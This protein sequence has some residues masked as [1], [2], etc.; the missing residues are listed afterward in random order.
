MR[1]DGEKLIGEAIKANN[2]AEA[3]LSEIYQRVIPYLP[4]ELV[5]DEFFNISS[6]NNGSEIFFTTDAELGNICVEDV[7]ALINK[8][9]NLTMEDIKQCRGI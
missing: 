2:I 9:G 7:I 3:A 6:A 1:I 5:E 8:K 4:E